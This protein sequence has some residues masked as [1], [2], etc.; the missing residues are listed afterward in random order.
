MIRGG[1]DSKVATSAAFEHA[2]ET[3]ENYPHIQHEVEAK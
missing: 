2:N 3:F 1:G